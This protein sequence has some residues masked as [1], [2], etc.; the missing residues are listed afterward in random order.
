MPLFKRAKEKLVSQKTTNFKTE[1]ELQAL[2]EKNL[3]EVFKCKFIATEFSTGAEHAGRIDTLALS[4]DANPVI[5][6]YKKSQSSELITQSLY[7]LSWLN[8]HKGDFEIAAKRSLGNSLEIDWSEIRVICIAPNF[9]KF[10]LHA[11]RVMRSNIELWQYRLYEDGSL[12]FDEV[13]RKATGLVSNM[14]D[15]QDGKNPVMVAAGKK[16]AL[17]RAAGVYDVR[18]HVEKAD[19]DLR[20]ILESLREFALSLD[21]SVEETPKKHYIAYKIAQN[22]VCIEVQ[23]RKLCL[24]LKIDPKK[25]GALPEG[26]RDVTDIGHFGTGNLEFTVKQESDFKT[27]QK[28]IRRAYEE[29]G[30]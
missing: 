21:E 2:I 1:K 27:A 3:D 11:V 7:Y 28:L 12:Y 15:D 25:L 30:G 23:K 24:F 4:E 13:F 19:E 22:F 17:T 6:E 26:A 20:P 14:V 10:D 16:A 8:D 9:S 29:V 18:Q 5:I